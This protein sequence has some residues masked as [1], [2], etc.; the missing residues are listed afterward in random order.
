M[1]SLVK[2][3]PIN[4]GGKLGNMLVV[5]PTHPVQ[6]TACRGFKMLKQTIGLA[7]LFPRLITSSRTTAPHDHL[8]YQALT[9]VITIVSDRY[10]DESCLGLHMWRCY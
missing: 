8:A 2:E 9:P 1:S 3:S 7:S 6:Y 5:V 4:S 10:P